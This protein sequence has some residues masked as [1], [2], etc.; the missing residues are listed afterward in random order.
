MAENGKKYWPKMNLWGQ[1]GLRNVLHKLIQQLC[2]ILTFYEIM[3][4]FLQKSMGFL[5]ISNISFPFLS[6]LCRVYM[7]MPYILCSPPH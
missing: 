5:G 6:L 3:A 1:S 2:H 7:N 4:A